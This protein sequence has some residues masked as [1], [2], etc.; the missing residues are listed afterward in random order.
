MTFPYEFPVVFEDTTTPFDTAGSV[1]NAAAVELGLTEDVDPYASSDANF[2]QL[3][4]LLTKLGRGLW[5][6]RQWT[7]LTQEHTFATVSGTASYP[8]PDGFGYLINQSEWDR[9]NQRPLGGPLTSQQWQ[10]LK[11]SL[12]AGISWVLH[13]RLRQ[14]QLQLYP[15]TAIPDAHTIA[16]EYVSRFWVQPSAET[17]PTQ[18]A[19][20]L[21]SDIIWF[22]PELV[23]AGLK[24]YFLKAKGFPAQDAQTEYDRIL[25]LVMGDDSPAPVLHLDGRSYEEARLIDGANLP[26]SGWGQ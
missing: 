18:D 13:F 8:L 14:M 22:D 12:A 17:Q 26:Y 20:I 23:V 4:R 16:F 25:Q 21:S 10:Y 3:R 24:L 5:R 2:V 15:D 11:G 9:T 1:I 6:E 7:Q 19:P